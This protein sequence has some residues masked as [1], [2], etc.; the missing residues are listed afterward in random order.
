MKKII[1]SFVVMLA[2][3]ASAAFAN[4]VDTNPR[5]IESFKREF[6]NAEL[7]K[8]SVDN[9]FT[10]ASFVLGGNRAVALFNAEG[11]LVGSMRDLL[12][13]QLPLSVMTSI[14]KRF[15]EASTMDIRELSNAEGTRYQLTLEHK[16]RSYTVLAFHDG[17]IAEIRKA[18]K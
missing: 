15:P 9:E 16:G 7:V 10:K 11:E 8:W 3:G 2:V 1:L 13:N 4:P 12:Y 18:K 5:A 14:D 6:A 17:T